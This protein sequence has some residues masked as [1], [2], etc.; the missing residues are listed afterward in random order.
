MDLRN[1]FAKVLDGFHQYDNMLAFF[2]GN[3]V[4]NSTNATIA[5]P[6]VKAVIADMKAYRDFMQYRKIPIG[7]AASLQSTLA[8]EQNYFDCGNSSIS[9]DFF[10]L[11]AYSWCGQSTF[12]ESG[13][14]TLYV[15][16]D[17]YD[18]PIFLSE[19]GCNTPRPRDFS[20]QVAVLG[21]QMNDRF[22]GSV[23]YEWHQEINNYGLANYSNSAFTGTPTLIGEYTSLKN[24]WATLVPVGVQASSYDP[25]LTKR[26]CPSSV[27]NSWL[28]AAAAGTSIP[29]LGLSGFTAP[30]SGQSSTT[31]SGSGTGGS[32]TPD[33][34]GK[35]GNSGKSSKLGGGA[36]AGIIIGVLALL[37]LLIGTV[38]FI[39]RRKRAHNDSG[40]NDQPE[41]TAVGPNDAAHKHGQ[42]T[43]P[44]MGGGRERQ[45]LGPPQPHEL[46]AQNQIGEL[47]YQGDSSYH[48]DVPYQQVQHPPIF[49][50][51]HANEA[52]HPP[53]PPPMAPAVPS[54]HVQAQR[55]REVEWL[56]S[57]E[58]RMRQ[59]RE[60]LMTQN[61]NP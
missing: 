49:G 3:E 24:Q 57:E 12:T 27:A 46:R 61:P 7:Y 55:R 8:L 38:F 36:I 25:S 23:I 19:T 43:I 35:G 47:P 22:S 42:G 30:R 41:I 48:Q 32:S 15:N 33:K 28:V 17:G 31:K 11:N 9:A 51:V 40:T 26:S 45:E 14:N 52:G 4:I 34:G 10:G 58:A 13:Y 21:R 6:A 54:E 37:L 59:R 20:D 16:A 50:G 2:A 44:E 29:T 60:Q 39:L 5:A 18:I 56:E 1:Q 53:S